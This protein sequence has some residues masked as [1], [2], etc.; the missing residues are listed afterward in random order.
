[1]K[2]SR[3]SK[4]SETVETVRER[5]RERELYSSELSFINY[6]KNPI[7]ISKTNLRINEIINN[8]KGGLYAKRHIVCPFCVQKKLKFRY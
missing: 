5:E 4:I 6:A 8:T 7:K 1:M 3:K 2:N